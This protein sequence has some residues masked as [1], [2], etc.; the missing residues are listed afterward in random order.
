MLGNDRRRDHHQVLGGAALMS[1]R[2]ESGSR[3]NAKSPIDMSPIGHPCSTTGS[4]RAA[5]SRIRMT[6]SSVL[7][8]GQCGEVSA[9]DVTGLHLRGVRSLGNGAHGDVAVRDNPTN[10]AVVHRDDIAHVRVAHG[11]GGVNRR[12]CRRKRHRTGAH[13]LSHALGHVGLLSRGRDA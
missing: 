5:C 7:S 2:A 9:A 3:S 10:L 8:V 6:A 13:D 11:P 4:R 1:A 12:G